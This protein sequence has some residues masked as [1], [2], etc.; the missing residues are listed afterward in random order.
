MLLQGIGKLT[1][2]LTLVTKPTIHVTPSVS[3]YRVYMCLYVVILI[4]LY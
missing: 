3:V 4:K 2:L 1:C